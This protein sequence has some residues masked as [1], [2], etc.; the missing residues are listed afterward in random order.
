MRTAVTIRRILHCMLSTPLGYLRTI[1]LWLVTFIAAVVVMADSSLAINGC[2]VEFVVGMFVLS[3]LTPVMAFAYLCRCCDWNVAMVAYG[4]HTMLIMIRGKAK[5][6]GVQIAA[7]VIM[8]A[9]SFV[10]MYGL[11]HSI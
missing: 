10:A 8:P 6:R 5:C 9:Q 1:A 4:W 3:L 7:A 11:T 2:I